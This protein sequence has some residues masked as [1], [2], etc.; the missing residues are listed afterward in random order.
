M[1]RPRLPFRLTTFRRRWKITRGIGEPPVVEGVREGSPLEGVVLPGDRVLELNGTR[2]RDVIDFLAAAMEDEVRLLLERGGRVKGVR[3]RKGEGVPLGLVFPRPVFDGVITC[4]NRCL[5][6]FVDRLPPG[7]RPGLY[8]KDDDYRLSFLFGN[9]VTLN[10]LEEGEL[11]RILDLRLSPLYVSLH[12]TDS[13]LRSYLMGGNGRKGLE[14]LERLA[15]AGLELHLQVVVCPGI[16]DGEA[17][18]ATM[19]EA[20]R[21]F[22]PA[23]L[24][25]VPVG[26]AHAHREKVLR[27][28]GREEAA[29]VLELV[30][31]FRERACREVGEGIYQASDEF[32]LLAGADLPPAEDYDGYPQLENGVGMIRK[33]LDELEEEKARF[34]E[35]ARCREDACVLT[36]KA[37][38]PLLARVL[39]GLPGGPPAVLAPVNR[40]F[41]ESVTVAALLCGEDV[42]AAIR[43]SELRPQRV[44]LPE[45]L[46]SEGSFLDGRTLEEVEGEVGAE[47]VPLP[48]RGEALLRAL[49]DLPWEEQGESSIGPADGGSLPGEGPVW[50]APFP[51][52]NREEFP[53]RPRS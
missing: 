17:L 13:G 7:L 18:K 50:H 44:L 27:L 26:L 43:A 4:R 40:L 19:E 52:G 33:F 47:L 30:A 28:P 11:R 35:V 36:G 51:G 42:A 29:R 2:P 1:K 23:S 12:S 46:L 32:Y 37:F 22:R 39:E 38:A 14:A 41:G 45:T 8:Q 6:C 31:A 15:E 16:N 25:L 48:V 53:G 49:A 10:N 21:R 9:F 24:A 34:R 5:F 20:W 3:V